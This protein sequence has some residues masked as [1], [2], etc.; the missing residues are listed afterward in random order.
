MSVVTVAICIVA[1]LLGG[2]AWLV[3][4]RLPAPA[5]V[6]FAVAVCVTLL[7]YSA[8]PAVLGG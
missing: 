8:G 1:A 3:V 7:A 4:E 2:L 5:W 6:V